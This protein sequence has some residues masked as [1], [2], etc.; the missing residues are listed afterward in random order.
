[1]NFMQLPSAYFASNRLKDVDVNIESHVDADFANVIDDRHAFL[2]AGGPIS[3]QSRLQVT[4]AASNIDWVTAYISP[5]SDCDEAYVSSIAFDI[6]ILLALRFVQHLVSSHII[7]PL[8]TSPLLVDLEDDG[9]FVFDLGHLVSGL[10]AIKCLAYEI[11]C[12]QD[13]HSVH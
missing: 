13:N 5:W 11:P 4:V 6:M 9:F 12:K 1:M 7:F 3:R 10:P 2:F 8:R